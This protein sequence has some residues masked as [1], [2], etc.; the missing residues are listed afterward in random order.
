MGVQ[1][2]DSRS[3]PVPVNN[4]ATVFDVI[5]E[6]HNFRLIYLFTYLYCSFNLVDDFDVQFNS[7]SELP[8]MPNK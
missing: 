7:I 3:A 8:S 5:E 1:R 6:G 2:H 4:E